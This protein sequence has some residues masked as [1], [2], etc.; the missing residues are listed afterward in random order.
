MRRTLLPAVQTTHFRPQWQYTS[1]SGEAAASA[2]ASATAGAAGADAASAD[3]GGAP[4]ATAEEEGAGDPGPPVSVAAGLRGDSTA[5]SISVHTSS[6]S[7]S[8]EVSRSAS[9]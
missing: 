4:V 2:A 9:R 3:A 1:G 7:R 8:A 5:C 6:V